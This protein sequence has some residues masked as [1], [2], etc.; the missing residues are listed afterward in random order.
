MMNGL[1]SKAKRCA[2]ALGSFYCCF[3]LFFINWG[4]THHCDGN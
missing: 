3:S 2:M 1:C 4:W